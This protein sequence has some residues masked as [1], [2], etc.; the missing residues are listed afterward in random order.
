MLKIYSPDRSPRLEYV[1]KHLFQTV[2]GIDFR[3]DNQLD[4]KSIPYDIYYC[5]KQEGRGLH[6][7]PHSLLFESDIRKQNV[8]TGEWEGLTT[9]FTNKGEIPFDIF[10]ATFFL[11]SRYEEYTCDKKDQHGRFLA[12]NSIAYKNNFLTHPLID[13]WA[14]KLKEIILSNNPGLKFQ[15][16]CFQI[17]PTIDVDNVYAYRYHGILQTI[18]CSVRD[19]IKSEKKKAL[20]RIRCVLRMQPDPYYN[21]EEVVDWHINNGFTPYLFFHCGGFGKFDKRTLLPSLEYKKLR[22][23]LSQKCQI[24]IHPSYQAAESLPRFKWEIWKM[25]QGNPQFS[26]TP[27]CRYHYLRFF[28][29]EGYRKLISSGI[30]TDWSLCYSNDPGFRA[31]TSFPFQFFDLTTNQESSLLLYPTAVMDKTL[32]S[33]L[34]LSIEESE[35]Y[36]LKMAEEVKRVNGTFITLFHN[37]HLTNGFGWDGWKE[38]YQHLLKKLQETL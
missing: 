35:K 24:G 5:E 13:L 29:P 14:Q 17:I 2:L 6:I 36:I 18:Y 32:K 26:A 27:N 1:C 15:S 28:L 23:K 34:Q 9:L 38:G 12:E 21:L 22:G 16:P 30:K 25:S 19:V 20:D 8:T 4:E 11:L 10:S 33:N 3:I 37:Q 31:S 7:H